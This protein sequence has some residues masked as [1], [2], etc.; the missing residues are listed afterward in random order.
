MTYLFEL[1]VQE[2]LAKA[3]AKYRP[4]HSIHEGLA[5]IR[6]EYREFEQEVFK[7]NQDAQQMLNELVQLAAMCQRVAEDT[8]LISAVESDNESAQKNNSNRL[9]WSPTRI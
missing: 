9:R 5:V 8:Y 3:R 2:E 6:E 7:Q 4:I 1:R